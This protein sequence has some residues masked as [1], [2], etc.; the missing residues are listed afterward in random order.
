MS[1]YTWGFPKLV[2]LKLWKLQ[3]LEDWDVQEKAM[4]N[5]RE[6]EIRSCIKLRVPS[7][8]K[9]LKNHTKL[10]LTDMPQ[11]F[12]AT[13]TRT[14]AQIWDDITHSPAIITESW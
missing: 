11:E 8:L 3:L 12:S 7:G 6:L 9:Q 1:C 5:L 2:V 13:I 10:K 14:R 4:R